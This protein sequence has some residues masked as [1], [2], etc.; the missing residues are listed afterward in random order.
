MRHGIEAPLRDMSPCSWIA[1]LQVVVAQH[2]HT[3]IKLGRMFYSCKS[4]SCRTLLVIN[5]Y[6]SVDNPNH[7]RQ[8]QAASETRVQPVPIQENKGNDAPN[9]TNQVA[10]IRTV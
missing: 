6:A 3:G 7:N 8:E 2:Q 9:Q 10:D 4:C 5:S 1:P